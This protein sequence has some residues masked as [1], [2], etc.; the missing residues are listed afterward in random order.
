MHTGFLNLFLIPKLIYLSIYLSMYMEQEK[1]NEEEEEGSSEE[2]FTVSPT[3]PVLTEA[4]QER[5]SKE[6]N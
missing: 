3:T 2:L 5:R 1:N 4:V 6:V